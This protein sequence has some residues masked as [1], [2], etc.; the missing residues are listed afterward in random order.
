M[1]ETR[2]AT[3]NELPLIAEFWFRMACEMGEI[4]GIPLPDSQKVNEVE[5]L[6]FK[7]SEN[8]NLMFRV[9]ESEKKEI[10]ACAGGLLRKEY[11]FPLS[12]EQTPFG[13]IIAV[14]TLPQHRGNGLAYQ[15]VDEVCSWLKDN[16]AK[17]ARLWSSSRA[18]KLYESLGFKS[19]L[20]MEKP[21]G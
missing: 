6:F 16:G 9:A 10:V 1:Y 5:R 12:E 3:K 13:W 11:F 19:M 20:D 7:E 17:R 8:G 18:R 15:L 4:D 14:Y 21:L 2:W